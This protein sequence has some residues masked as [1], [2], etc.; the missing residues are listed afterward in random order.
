MAI[1][2]GVETI[3]SNT[4]SENEGLKIYIPNSV[5]KIEKNMFIHGYGKIYIE[6]D[7]SREFVEANWDS[8]WDAPSATDHHP[9]ITVKYLR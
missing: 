9:D 6:I 5:K 1:Q 4:F 7:N 3:K 2:E 8:G